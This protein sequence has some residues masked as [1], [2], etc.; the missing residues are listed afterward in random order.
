MPEDTGFGRL[1]T[2]AEAEAENTPQNESPARLAQYPELRKPF[3]FLNARWE[4]LKASMQP[5]DALYEFCS[6]LNSWQT[7]CGR[8]GIRLVRNGKIVDGIVTT[9]N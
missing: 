1:T 9:M 6:D 8:A 3:G 4:Q 5:G 7:L 2:V